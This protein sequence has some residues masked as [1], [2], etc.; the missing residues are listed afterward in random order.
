VAW[1]TRYTTPAAGAS[2]I[3]ASGLRS[4]VSMNPDRSCSRRFS[5]KTNGSVLTKIPPKI[6]ADRMTSS[7]RS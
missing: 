6:L 7:Y 1:N 4:Q 2:Q 3:T 5:K